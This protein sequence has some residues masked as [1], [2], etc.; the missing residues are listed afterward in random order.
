MIETTVTD[1]VDN[2]VTAPGAEVVTT[3]QLDPSFTALLG[4]STAAEEKTEVEQLPPLEMP[5]E[6]DPA[7]IKLAEEAAKNAA[8]FL[9]FALQESTGRSYNLTEQAANKLAKGIAP[10]LVKYGVGEP[11]AL[12][13]K[14]KVEIDALMALGA[15]GYGMYKAHKQYQKEEKEAAAHGN[16]S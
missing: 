15:L 3:Q 14:W 9:F 6:L 8:G 13:I 16:Q 10:C 12:F 2:G 11:S 1:Q 7:R 5:P 4:E